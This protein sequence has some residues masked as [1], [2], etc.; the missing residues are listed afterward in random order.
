MTAP[1]AERKHYGKIA[2]SGLRFPSKNVSLLLRMG[3]GPG[4]AAFLSSYI[5]LFFFWPGVD[6]T[7]TTNSQAFVVS[8]IT[9]FSKAAYMLAAVIYMVRVHRFIIS[10][11]EPGGTK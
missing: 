9:L 1:R 7:L 5:V 4:L 11:E 10:G 2:I 8:T 3:F 6:S